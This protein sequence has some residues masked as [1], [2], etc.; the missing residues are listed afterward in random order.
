MLATFSNYLSDKEWNNSPAI[1]IAEDKNGFRIEVALPGME[2]EDFKIHVEK[3]ILEISSEKELTS[4]TK[5]ERFLRKEFSYSK[6]KRRFSIPEYVDSE[7]IKASYK[8][9][10]LNV[11]IPKREE[12]KDKVARSINVE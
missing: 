1:N 4:E 7:N 10:I 8:N 6:F 3:K 5:D 2:K 9:G 11:S 12:T